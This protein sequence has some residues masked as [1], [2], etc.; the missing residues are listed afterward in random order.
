M[1]T[2]RIAT[3]VCALCLAIPAAAG[4]SED[5]NAHG[6][7]GPDGIIPA[8][9]GSAVTARGPYGIAPAGQP[10]TVK[11]RGPYGTPPA[12][13]RRPVKASGP[14]GTPPAGPRTPVKAS[15]PYGIPPG[16]GSQNTTGPSIH[17]RGASGRD[18]TNGWR[19]A[20]IS[21]AALLAT[22]LLGFALLVPARRRPADMVT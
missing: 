3:G 16:T 13:P 20:A 21:E 9:P 17:G 5:T 7:R 10:S 18:D 11:A 2:R 1:L 14:Y 12:G 15:G 6:A 19:T 22:V 4:A 8:G